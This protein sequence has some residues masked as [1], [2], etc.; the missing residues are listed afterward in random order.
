MPS[1]AGECHTDHSARLH[2]AR[3]RGKVV[4]KNL[5]LIQYRWLRRRFTAVGTTLSL[6]RILPATEYKGN[7]IFHGEPAGD[8]TIDRSG[9]FDFGALRP[10]EY[11]L[12][13]R[14]PGEDGVGFGVEIDPTARITEVLI[15]PSPAYY[16]TCLGWNFEPR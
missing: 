14:M 8:V 4:G 11:G 12:T 3:L 6:R 5:W 16:C 13:V 2:V 9:T 7:V 15:D 10:G 1:L